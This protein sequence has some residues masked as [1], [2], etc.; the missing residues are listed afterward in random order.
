MR[1]AGALADSERGK[2]CRDCG[3]GGGVLGAAGAY[4]ASAGDTAD[5]G[6]SGMVGDASGKSFPDAGDEEFL[7]RIGVAPGAPGADEFLSVGIE[8]H[9]VGRGFDAAAV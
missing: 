8:L 1:L 5:L 6:P 9:A 4:A 7:N 2:P 3:A